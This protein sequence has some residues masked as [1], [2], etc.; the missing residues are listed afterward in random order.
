MGP[1][2]I[3]LALI[4]SAGLLL[5]GWGASQYR[6][7]SV[8]GPMLVE[9]VAVAV[10]P[11]GRIFCVSA[12]GRVHKYDSEGRGL[13]AF[14]LD[15]GGE[16]VVIG[17]DDSG[18][19]EIASLAAR[20]RWIYDSGGSRIL[21]EVDPEGRAHTRLLAGATQWN[22]GP[23]GLEVALEGGHIVARTGGVGGDVRVLVPAAPFPLSLFAR[24]PWLL[25]VGLI[26][27]TFGLMASMIL[28][29]RVRD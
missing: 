14:M 24:M 5:S 25:V 17:V 4:C 23:N 12:L 6:M 9:P 26:L 27:S 2:W 18:E 15:E 20:R 7:A 8:R 28:P 29:F 11:E 22:M 21:D 19:L 13:G 16:A 1:K 3:A 10:T